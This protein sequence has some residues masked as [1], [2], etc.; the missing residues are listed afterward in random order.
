MVDL[1]VVEGVEESEENE[2]ES[3]TLDFESSSKLETK[4]KLKSKSSD[5]ANAQGTCPF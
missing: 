3:I 2:V 1:E 4:S 5:P